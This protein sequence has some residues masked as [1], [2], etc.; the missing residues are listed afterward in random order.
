MS[1]ARIRIK[2]AVSKRGL[3]KSHH[4]QCPPYRVQCHTWSIQTQTDLIGVDPQTMCGWCWAWCTLSCCPLF[5]L[6]NSWAQWTLQHHHAEPEHLADW[7]AT[8]WEPHHADTRCPEHVLSPV[9]AELHQRNPSSAP[10]VVGSKVW[11]DIRAGTTT[12]TP[13]EPLCRH[14]W[15]ISL[16]NGNNSPSQFKYCMTW[17]ILSVVIGIGCVI[18]Q[19]HRHHRR[20][21]NHQLLEQIRSTPSRTKTHW[22]AWQDDYMGRDWWHM[23]YRAYWSLWCVWLHSTWESMCGSKTPFLFHLT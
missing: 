21:L 10:P 19:Q 11:A 4:W 7:F 12:E 6:C 3:S 8:L 16:P 22:E 13:A 1:N 17:I 20:Q 14:V 15:A 5:G 23:W 18:Y 2:W 9:H